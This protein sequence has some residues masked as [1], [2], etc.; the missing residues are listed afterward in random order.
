MNQFDNRNTLALRA[1]EV[2]GPE[3]AEA[4]MDAVSMGDRL[5]LNL[6]RFQAEMDQKFAAIDQKFAAIDQK[7]VNLDRAILDSEIRIR[8][9]V[10]RD[11]T[12][13]RRFV[14]TTTIGVAS[15]TLGVLGS[16]MVAV[17][18]RT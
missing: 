5:E 10:A 17:L 16:L 6:V 2:L 3:E 18:L 7:F 8:A 12:A 4:L 13:T 11:L 15:I 9:E 14:V 1:S